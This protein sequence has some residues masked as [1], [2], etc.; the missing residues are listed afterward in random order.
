MEFDKT[1]WGK[2]I[3]Y[4]SPITGR[5]T[6]LYNLAVLATALGRT[7]QTVRKWEV[8][9]LIPPTPFRLHN[10]R[11]YTQEHIE[12]IVRCAEK[13]HLTTGVS[14]SRTSFSKW[15]HEEFQK[16]N[17]LFFKEEG[18]VENGSQK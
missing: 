12:A 11:M 18:S 14:Y 16:V 4:K 2:K 6:Y 9:G 3:P 5:E 10:R 7:S 1:P 13:A 15:V 8:S 17:D